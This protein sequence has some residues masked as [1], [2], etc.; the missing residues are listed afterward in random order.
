MVP[1][2]GILTAVDL[3]H[4]VPPFSK[5]RWDLRWAYAKNA[6]LLQNHMNWYCTEPS[7][8]ISA[9]VDY[10]W[11]VRE[12]NRRKEQG[13]AD[14]KVYHIDTELAHE[15]IE[16]R[17]ARKLIERLNVE[18][19]LNIGAESVAEHECLFLHEIPEETIFDIEIL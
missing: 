19:D 10:R 12:A 14:V 17:Y 11:A 18:N 4:Q 1:G 15:R 6:Q 2:A 9:T 5:W 8:F 7:P 3:H 16:F 13:H